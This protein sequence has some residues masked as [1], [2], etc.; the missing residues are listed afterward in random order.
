MLNNE[1]FKL[2][3]DV[4]IF[5]FLLFTKDADLDLNSKPIISSGISSWKFSIKEGHFMSGSFEAF[6]IG[7]FI[8][9]K[10][11]FAFSGDF[12]NKF[13]NSSSSE[14]DGPVSG[15]GLGFGLGEGAFGFGLGEGAF[16]FG[17]VF[18][19]LHLPVLGL[20]ILFFS[21]QIFSFAGV[22]LLVG[23]GFATGFG[24]GVGFTADLGE[25]TL[26][27]GATGFGA[28]KLESVLFELEEL[29]FLKFSHNP[30]FFNSFSANPV[31]TPFA[32]GCFF[33]F[34]LF[35]LIE[36]GFQ[37]HPAL[38]VFSDL[39]YLHF[40]PPVNRNFISLYL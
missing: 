25:D 7:D 4:G 26:V 39:Q 10:N 1:N 30:A 9:F 28:L 21:S 6:K 34:I 24:L 16:G 14:D 20:Q 3:F 36:S 27:L 2:V 15:F 31:G 22:H 37:G 8:W 29:A 32:F 40:P 17:L 23:V 33:A 5:S 35:F 11:T 19:T 13:F 38:V 18:I 12:G